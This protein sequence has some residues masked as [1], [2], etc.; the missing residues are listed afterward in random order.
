MTKPRDSGLS[1]I[2]SISSAHLPV[3]HHP[4]SK[5]L[6]DP[7]TGRCAS[8]EGMWASLTTTETLA[9][10][11]SSCE[12]NCQY[13][14]QGSSHAMTAPINLHPVQFA[15]CSKPPICTKKAPTRA[16]CRN[17]FAEKT[18]ARRP[19][20]EPWG[21]AD[22]GQPLQCAGS[23]QCAG[24]VTPDTSEQLACRRGHPV[25]TPLECHIPSA[26]DLEYLAIHRTSSTLLSIRPNPVQQVTGGEGG[27]GESISR[28]RTCRCCRKVYRWLQAAACISAIRP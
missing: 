12:L 27:E 26:I 3:Q 8:S 15:P 18:Q 4:A 23:S 2:G 5:V 6:S 14:N 28:S 9:G 25:N 17:Y 24:I 10:P 19:K 22:S 21:L 13:E 20:K 7:A 1:R 11:V 16:L